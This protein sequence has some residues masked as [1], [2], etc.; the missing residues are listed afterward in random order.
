MKYLSI[1]LLSFLVACGGDSEEKKG[2]KSDDKDSTETTDSKTIDAKEVEENPEEV[3]MEE[4]EKSGE[5]MSLCDCVKKTKELEAISMNSDSDEEMMAAL[6]ELG[7]LRDG[8]CKI[9][10][11]GDQGSPE[12]RADRQRQIK[13]CK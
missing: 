12:E 5:G 2:D 8:D 10:K 9:L 4:F 6:D 1:L 7:K 3:S 13:A 11:M